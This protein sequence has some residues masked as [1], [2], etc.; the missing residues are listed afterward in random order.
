MPCG[1][2]STGFNGERAKRGL[3][4][5]QPANLLFPAIQ[6]H[7]DLMAKLGRLDHLFLGDGSPQERAEKAK[8]RGGSIGEIIA[9]GQRTA[10]EVVEDWMFS[11]GHR[12]AILT[13]SFTEFSGGLA[14]DKLGRKWWGVILGGPLR[15]FGAAPAMPSLPVVVARGLR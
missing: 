9:Y 8:Y 2:C 12:R 13:S 6:P 1:P 15:G 7:C 10:A 3:R 11:A 5:L 4:V 14:E